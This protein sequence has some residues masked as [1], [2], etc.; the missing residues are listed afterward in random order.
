MIGFGAMMICDFR[1]VSN[2]GM[3]LAIGI[4]FA[5]LAALTLMSSLVVL[6]GDKLFWP[7]G[8]SGPKREQGYL[9]AMG[10]AAHKYF[11]ISTHF[12]IKHAKLIVV[13][14]ILFT[15]P[16]AYVYA[17][18]NTSYDMIGSMM[19]GESQEGMRVMS[20]FGDGGAVTAGY[21]GTGAYG[22]RPAFPRG[23]SAGIF[24]PD[25]REKKGGTEA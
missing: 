3:G 20:D 11:D 12:S 18:S 21:T 9:K 23:L 24:T 15:V 19:T 6:L 2:M 16:M 25:D 10:N 13:V 8:A 14:T 4:V 22:R 5:L 1:L 17:T 7:S